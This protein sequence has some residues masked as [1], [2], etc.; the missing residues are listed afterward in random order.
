M[1]RLFGIALAGSL[2]ALARYGLSTWIQ[3]TWPGPFPWGTLAVNLLGSFF[4]GLVWALA[5]E[6]G[7]LS[8][9]ARIILLSGFMGAFTTFST[10]MFESGQLLT[11]GR[12]VLAAANI[13]LQVVAGLGCLFLG[14]ALGR[15]GM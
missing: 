6:R 11:G 7:L 5:E 1:Y 12:A 13:G 10:L 3:N 4:F 2:G 14:L 8:Q 9:E 15:G